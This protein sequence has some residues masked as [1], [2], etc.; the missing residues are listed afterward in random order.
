MTNQDGADSVSAGR[1]TVKQAATASRTSPI[2]CDAGAR[3]TAPSPFQSPP[4]VDDRR[5]GAPVRF[6]RC[7]LG[8]FVLAQLRLGLLE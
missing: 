3:A 1:A 6:K 2:D 7:Q 8:H 4:V 5:I